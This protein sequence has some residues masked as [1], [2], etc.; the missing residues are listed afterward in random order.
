M[1]SCELQN[2][3]LID[4]LSQLSVFDKKILIDYDF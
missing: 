2:N 3:T 1:N 4:W